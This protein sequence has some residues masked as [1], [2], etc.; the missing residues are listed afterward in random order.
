[1]FSSAVPGS[2]SHVLLPTSGTRDHNI[3]EISKVLMPLY[4]SLGKFTET[5]ESIAACAVDVVVIHIPTDFPVKGFDMESCPDWNQRDLSGLQ[6]RRA[7][8]NHFLKLEGTLLCVCHASF[9]GTVATY[10][11]AF[12]FCEDRAIGIFTKGIHGVL[13]EVPVSSICFS[14]SYEILIENIVYTNSIFLW[15]NVVCLSSFACFP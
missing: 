11:N 13:N 15:G 2:Y 7:I 6:N 9:S 4:Q 8:A 14:F 1:M 10:A 5:S 12:D 3:L